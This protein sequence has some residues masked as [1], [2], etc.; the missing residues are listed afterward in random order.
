MWF[1]ERL[2]T[3]LLVG[4]FIRSLSQ[5]NSSCVHIFGIMRTAS[6]HSSRFFSG[7][8]PKGSISNI[9]AE[10]PVPNSNRP[11][12]MMS[13]VAARSATRTGWL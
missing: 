12:L 1:L 5:E 6:S 8:T 4:T 13:R 3:T 11:L 9:V 10:R 2:G 7:S